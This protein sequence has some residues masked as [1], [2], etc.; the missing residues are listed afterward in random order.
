MT[1][2]TCWVHALDSNRIETHADSSGIEADLPDEAGFCNHF[3]SRLVRLLDREDDQV[4]LLCFLP[5]PILGEEA[6]I[7]GCPGQG[8]TSVAEEAKGDF[9][10]HVAG[11]DI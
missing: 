5:V 9:C 4:L 11:D 8:C 1:G 7:V 2:Q 3:D 10:S 6:G